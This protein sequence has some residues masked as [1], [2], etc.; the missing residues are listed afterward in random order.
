MPTPIKTPDRLFD[1]TWRPG[2]PYRP[3]LSGR[4][5]WGMIVLFLILSGL[6]GAYRY[7]T[8]ANR[9]RAQAEQYL[10]KLTGGHASVRK[11]TLSIFEGL[12]LDEVRV[13]TDQD[14]TEDSLIFSA[15]TFL[16]H[17]SPAA[18]LQGDIE[19]THIVAIDPRMRLTENVDTHEWNYALLHPRKN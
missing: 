13:Y 2:H 15:S 10:A 7:F 12:R 1:R 6:I 17:Y 4:R 19:A 14:K 18:L 11:A 8:N 3:R 9:V 5:R 16:I